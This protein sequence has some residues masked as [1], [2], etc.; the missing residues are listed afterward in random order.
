[1]TN[2]VAVDRATAA[3]INPLISIGYT[4]DTLD[5]CSEVIRLVGSLAS[6]DT[7][8]SSDYLWLVFLVVVRAMEWER[9]NITSVKCRR[10]ECARSHHE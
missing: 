8:A 1:M 6:H 3:R 7:G 2:E 5:Q 4:E 9:D 10:G